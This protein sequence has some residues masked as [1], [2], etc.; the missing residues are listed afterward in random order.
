MLVSKSTQSSLKGL[1]Q[2]TVV[3]ATYS[4]HFKGANLKRP[5]IRIVH[6]LPFFLSSTSLAPK[7]E[8]CCIRNCHH[9]G[10]KICVTSS[11]VRFYAYMHQF[12]PCIWLSPPIS[13]SCIWD[14]R[15]STLLPYFSFL[16]HLC[17]WLYLGSSG[18][19]WA[20]RHQPSSMST[21]SFFGNQSLRPQFSIGVH[22]WYSFS[23]TRPIHC[24]P[25]CWWLAERHPFLCLGA[26]Y[27]WSGI[28]ALSSLLA[29]PPSLPSRL[30][31]LS[32]SFS[33]WLFWRPSC[34]MWQQW[35]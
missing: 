33:C 14:F 26:T 15:I 30:Y 28:Q 5:K 6:L 25:S 23:G 1:P 10:G 4:N 31:V 34:G 22:F 18:V 20:L 8:K 16:S 35:G 24:Y 12:T 32:L 29:G 7:Q 2:S 21:Q 27:V 13:S 11:C 17:T 3:M 19:V 9:P